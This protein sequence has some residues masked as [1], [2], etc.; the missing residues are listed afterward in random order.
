MEWSR[1][2]W[3][4]SVFL[5]TAPNTVTLAP[6]APLE[7]E[8]NPFHSRVEF[9]VPFMK[10]TSVKGSFEDFSGLLLYDRDRPT[11]S[12]V[13]FVIQAASLHTGNTLRDK[14]LRSDDF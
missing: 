9:S 2:G 12:S 5:V 4:A 11:R 8:L 6:T 7:F 1:T 13:T 14:H 10:L 3:I